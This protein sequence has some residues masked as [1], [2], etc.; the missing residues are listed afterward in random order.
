MREMIIR[1]VSKPENTDESWNGKNVRIVMEGDGVRREERM[2]TFAAA[3]AL[4]AAFSLRI[5]SCLSCS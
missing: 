3:A 1:S 5:R 4:F 2:H